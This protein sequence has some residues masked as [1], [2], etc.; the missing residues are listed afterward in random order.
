MTCL[1]L[2][3]SVSGSTHALLTLPHPMTPQAL[4]EVEQAVCQTLSS[5]RRG[6]GGA[7]AGAAPEHAP[8]RCEAAETEYASWIPDRG[9]IEFDSWTQHLRVNHD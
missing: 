4:L 6:Y 9:T 7:G 2:I 3:H 8:Q 1:Q 5:M